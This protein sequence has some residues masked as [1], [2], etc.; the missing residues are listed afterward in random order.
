MGQ[1]RNKKEIKRVLVLNENET[2]Q[3]K[4]NL[5]DIAEAIL[6]RKFIALSTYIKA[7]INDL[8]IQLKDWKKKNKP[9]PVVGKK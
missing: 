3:T 7:Q 9:N 5:W 8:M 2:K 1:R 6:T 4:Q